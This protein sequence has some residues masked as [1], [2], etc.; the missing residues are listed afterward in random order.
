MPFFSS[1]AD[2]GPAVGIRHDLV[3]LAVHH[4]HGDPDLLEVLGKIGLRKGDDAVVVRLGAAHH[5]LTPPILDDTFGHLGA[6]P[7]ETVERTS[8]TSR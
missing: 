4:Q 3:V 7:V 6:G 8:G 5:A 1:F 2:S